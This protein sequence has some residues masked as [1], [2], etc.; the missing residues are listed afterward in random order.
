MGLNAQVIAIGQFTRT[1][2]PF[3]QYPGE[4][5]ARTREGVTSPETVFFVETG[6][7]ASVELASCFG[8]DALDFNQHELDARSADLERLR[9]M[10]GEDGVVRFQ[11]LREAGFRF[12]FLPNA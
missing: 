10:F 6:T 12:Y 8:V 5:Y 2:V 11:G 3:L 9:A 7:T 1:V 4:F